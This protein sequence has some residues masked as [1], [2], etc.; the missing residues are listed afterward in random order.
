MRGSADYR[1]AAADVFGAPG[2]PVEAALE[3]LQDMRRQRAN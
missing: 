2:L 1:R 3:V